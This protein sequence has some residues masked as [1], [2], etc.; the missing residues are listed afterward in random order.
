MRGRRVAVE[1]GPQVGGHVGIG[2]EPQHGVGLGELVGELLPVPL[3]EASHRD[4]LLGLRVP[5]AG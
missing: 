4:D 3:G 1:D 5:L 2:V